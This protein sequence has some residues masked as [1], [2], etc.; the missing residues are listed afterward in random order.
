RRGEALLQRLQEEPHPG[1]GGAARPAH[2]PALVTQ[3]PRPVTPAARRP[4]HGREPPEGIG[5]ALLQDR[6]D[7][8]V[9]ARRC[10]PST[11]TGR[12]AV[13]LAGLAAEREASGGEDCRGRAI[14]KSL[15]PVILF[16]DPLPISPGRAGAG[17]PRTVLPG[18]DDTGP[19]VDADRRRAG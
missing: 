12:Q 2:G 10:P 13:R 19:A 5:T 4:V 3:R 8:N 17:P 18:P 16:L 7:R 9:P 14:A 11:E 15:L 1:P 6:A